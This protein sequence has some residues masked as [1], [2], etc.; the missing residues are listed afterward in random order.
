MQA[1]INFI[2]ALILGLFDA[3]MAFIGLIDFHLS[4]AMTREGI[5]DQLQSV[6]L[7]VVTVFLVLL[8]LR[9]VGGLFGWLVLILLSLLLLHHLIPAMVQAGWVPGLQGHIF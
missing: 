4:D 2:I 8:A 5:G 9:L 7:L 3:I 1:A 6:I